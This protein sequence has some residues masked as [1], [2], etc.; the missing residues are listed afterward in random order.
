MSQNIRTKIEIPDWDLL[1]DSTKSLVSFFLAHACL[2][3]RGEYSGGVL[4]YMS[5][6]LFMDNLF[7]SDVSLLNGYGFAETAP[8]SILSAFFGPNK[9]DS[10]LSD[11]GITLS[12][13]GIPFVETWF[14]NTQSA[15]ESFMLAYV[16][17]TGYEY[18]Y[19][20]DFRR[21]GSSYSS[22]Y[23][24]HLYVPM[25]FKTVINNEVVEDSSIIPTFIMNGDV[26]SQGYHVTKFPI[27]STVFDLSYS[28][29]LRTSSFTIKYRNSNN[30]EVER[31]VFYKI[32]IWT[33]T[34][35][36]DNNDD[37]LDYFN[38][39]E[40]GYYDIN[41]VIDFILLLS[42]DYDLKL[43]LHVDD[44]VIYYYLYDSYDSES[45]TLAI[46]PR[47]NYLDGISAYRYTQ[48]VTPSKYNTYVLDQVTKAVI[49]PL[50]HL[51]YGYSL[52]LLYIELYNQDGTLFTDTLS[53][54][55]AVGIKE[56]SSSQANYNTLEAILSLT[57][58][59]MEGGFIQSEII[60]APPRP[61]TITFGNYPQSSNTP[62]PIEWYVLAEDTV[63][64]KSLIISK[65]ILD[66]QPYY[67]TSYSPTTW[68]N[69]TLRAWLN[70]TFYNSA[71]DSSEKSRILLSHIENPNNP[72]TGRSGGNDTDDYVFC[73][74]I[75]EAQDTN[76]FADDTAR[77]A[78]A[79][80][81]ATRMGCSD[82]YWWLRSPGNSTGNYTVYYRSAKI[83]GDGS[84]DVYGSDTGSTYVGVRPMMWISNS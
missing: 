51:S 83:Y 79:T 8:C 55:T 4:S 26:D 54:S 7:C 53:G 45:Q 65:R 75:Q 49:F 33:N 32:G 67:G 46:T 61:A 69:C 28:F 20:S 15:I 62:E 60:E 44:D 52:G 41:S 40:D 74:S 17:G 66:C 31:D 29:N 47:S 27:D 21:Q 1:N 22:P 57:D 84:V 42:T 24:L 56:T 14:N 68:E 3:F 10:Y 58:Q 43:H 9:S 36:Y 25:V 73:P 34:L 50:I 59:N 76:Y 70:S 82:N 81:Y 19:S 23:F 35:R 5:A 38:T 18:F 16:S 6:A 2:F 11:Q 37:P 77:K 71:F 30:V 12:Y 64:N 13:D 78:K 72:T 80:V 39:D 63:N 48:L